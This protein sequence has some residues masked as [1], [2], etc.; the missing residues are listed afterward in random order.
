MITD[1][2]FMN[3]NNIQVTTEDPKIQL[4]SFNQLIVLDRE[5]LHEY[6]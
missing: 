6:G 3:L 4:I 1:E 2:P 5:Q